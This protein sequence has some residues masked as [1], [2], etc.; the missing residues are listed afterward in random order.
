M[1]RIDTL[2]DGFAS[3]LDPKVLGVGDVI[4][5]RYKLTKELGNGG[6]GQVFVAENVAIGMR[7]AVK[8]LKP[9]LLENPE[10]RQRFQNEAQAVA[11]VAHPNV[12]HFYDLVVGDPTFIVMEYVRG[13]TLADVLRRDGRMPIARAVSIAHRL[14]W[15]LDAAHSAGVVH[16]DLKP[17]NVILSPD[18]EHGEV[19][20]LIDFGLAK[21]AATV[22]DQAKLTRTGQI[23]GTPQYMAPEQISGKPLDGRADVYSLGCVLWEML[24]GRALFGGID[25]VQVLYRQL[26]EKAAPPSRDVPEVPAALD[27]VLE[28]AL[29]KS[30]DSRFPTMRA[31]ASALGQVLH[32]LDPATLLPVGGGAHG[33]RVDETGSVLL[34]RAEENTAP[35]HTGLLSARSRWALLTWAAVATALLLIVGSAALLKWRARPKAPLGPGLLMVTTQPPGARVTVDGRVQEESTPTALRGLPLG[36]HD[37]ALSKAGYDSVERHV[38]LGGEGRLALDVALPPRMRKLEVV[39]EPAGAS[40]LLDGRLMPDATPTMVQLTEDDFHE[41]RAELNGYET[42]VHAIKPEDHEPTV[43]LTLAVER[44]ARGTLMVEARDVAEVWVDGVSTGLT[45]PTLG[46][47]V[48][49]GDHVIELRAASGDRSVP[50]KVHIERGQ[51]LRLSLALAAPGGRR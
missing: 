8:L 23:I 39:T 19:P 32:Q 51:T 17:A 50:R 3:L 41:L 26:H 36:G 21:L 13:E 43:K 37:I 12:A 16:R 38:T 47:H 40:L 25:D 28:L 29:G 49:A 46:F 44:Q 48:A 1:S 5:G 27:N 14:A 30:P 6:M 2:P 4:G 9:Q 15:G 33:V 31:M 35:L 20:K 42:T 24:V 18:V 10:F 11:A 22:A 34:E 7:V 45:T